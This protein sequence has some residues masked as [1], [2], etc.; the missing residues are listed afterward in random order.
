MFPGLLA[1]GLSP[2]F[3]FVPPQRAVMGAVPPAKHGQAGGIAMSSQLVGA[4]VGMAVC[5]TIFSMTGDF[6]AVFLATALVTGSVI[7]IGLFTIERPR[8]AAPVA[9]RE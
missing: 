7:V 5:S 6:W 4:T 9:A 2:A 3:L 1:W 8:A